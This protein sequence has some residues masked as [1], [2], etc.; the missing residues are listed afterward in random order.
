MFLGFEENLLGFWELI[1]WKWLGLEVFGF[2]LLG[3][4]EGVEFFL[5]YKWERIGFSWGC[6]KEGC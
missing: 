5:E 1:I 3:R 4:K 6:R 2:G